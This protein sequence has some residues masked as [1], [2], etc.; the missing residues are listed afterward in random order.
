MDDLNKY[1]GLIALIALIATIVLSGLTIFLIISLRNKIAG[2]RLKFLGFYSTDAETRETFAEFTV[3]NRSLNEVGISELGIKNGKVNFNLTKRYKKEMRM[4][5]ETRIV[6][7]QRSSITFTVSAEDLMKVLVDGK[8][9]KQVL[10][11]LRVYAVDLTGTLY[12]G[13]VPAVKKLLN[14]LLHGRPIRTNEVA[15]RDEHGEGFGASHAEA[16]NEVEGEVQEVA[17]YEAD[18]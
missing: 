6:I 11:T 4:K 10:R 5:P 14:E 9:G 7:E 2:Q 8:N 12:Q 18:E 16:A 13:R 3:G 15:G 17:S 1:A